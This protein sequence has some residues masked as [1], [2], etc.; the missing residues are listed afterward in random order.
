MELEYEVEAAIY[1]YILV[2][3]VNILKYIFILNLLLF[4]RLWNK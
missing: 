1:T 3:W 2:V 4:S